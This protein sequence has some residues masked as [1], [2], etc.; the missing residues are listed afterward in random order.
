MPLKDPSI[1]TLRRYGL[2]LFEFKLMAARQGNVCYV[3]QRLPKSEKLCCDHQHI[4]GWSAMP[5]EERKKYVR[6]LLCAWCNL[7]LVGRGMTALRARRIAA[8]LE[9][10][11]RRLG[12]TPRAE[13]VGKPG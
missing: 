1:N 13:T 6:G 12:E 5:R 8:Y 7:N 3:C 9:A 11:D 4:K 2:T 10:F